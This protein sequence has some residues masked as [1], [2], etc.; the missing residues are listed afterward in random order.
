MLQQLESKG[1]VRRRRSPADERRVL[2]SLTDEGAELLAPFRTRPRERQT[3]AYEAFAP[4]E[5]AARRPDG[6]SH[7]ARLR[8]RLRSWDATARRGRRGAVK[9]F[10]ITPEVA[11][12]E[13]VADP[14][15]GRPGMGCDIVMPAC[16][17]VPLPR[18][19]SG[20][21]ARGRRRRRG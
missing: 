1:M 13:T 18:G 4:V 17:G 3:R 6:P 16:P 10:P 5:R 7:G 15:P 8:L 12:A 21:S 14:A 9:P 20:R 2:V 19:R 11:G